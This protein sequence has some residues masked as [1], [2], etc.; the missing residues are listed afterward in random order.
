M[1]YAFLP[2]NGGGRGDAYL[3]WLRDTL[4]PLAASSLRIGTSRAQLGCAHEREAS[5]PW[6]TSSGLFLIAIHSSTSKQEN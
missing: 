5:N 6:P 1:R 3:D 4:V 2:R